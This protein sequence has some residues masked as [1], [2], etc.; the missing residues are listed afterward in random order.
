MST[1]KPGSKLKLTP[2]E[3][4]RLWNWGLHEDGLF[5]NRVGFLGA[6]QALMVT[7]FGSAG[8]GASPQDVRAWIAYAGMLV[9]LA[10]IYLWWYQI[11][12]TMNPV[13]RL[14]ESYIETYKVIRHGRRRWPG[15]NTV[16]GVVFPVLFLF[17]WLVLRYK[18][19]G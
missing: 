5:A 1:V 9:A 17:L 15:A 2:E 16:Q 14:L 3:V 6:T 13:K 12:R 7:A 10:S 8:A 11:Y 19:A 4:E 18:M